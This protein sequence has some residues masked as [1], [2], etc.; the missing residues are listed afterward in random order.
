[1]NNP[2]QKFAV[3]GML[4][5]MAIAVVMIVQLGAQRAAQVTG[6]FSN[7][8]TA[9]LRDAQGTVLLKGTFAPA[10]Q[11]PGEEEEVERKAPLVAATA[12]GAM[13]GEAEVEYQKATPSVQEVEF[14]AIGLPAGTA[15][16]LVID[17][18]TVASATADKNGKAEAEVEVR[19]AGL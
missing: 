2:V 9:E 14:T 13:T 12:G 7:A 18:K 8:Q 10:A 11:D 17:G 5:I 3:G 1:V 6:D 16:T 19:G 4:A 15:V